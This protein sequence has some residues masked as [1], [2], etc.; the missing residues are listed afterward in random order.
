M[1]PRR[2]NRRWRRLMPMCRTTLLHHNR[3]CQNRP[4]RRRKRIERR[5][6]SNPQRSSN[7]PDIR[8]RIVAIRRWRILVQKRGQAAAR[9]GTLIDSRTKR[10]FARRHAR[11]HRE[12]AILHPERTRTLRPRRPGPPHIAQIARV[13]VA[14]RSVAMQR[15]AAPIR[16]QIRGRIGCIPPRGDRRWRRWQMIAHLRA[17]SANTPRAAASITP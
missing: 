15:D 14:I 9:R 16:V 17:P 2:T 11:K 6:R 4:L 1:P 10:A 3:L 12:P 5:G 8:S 7:G 13:V